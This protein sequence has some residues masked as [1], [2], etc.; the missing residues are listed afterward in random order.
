VPL[1]AFARECQRR[2]HRVTLAG[3]PSFAAQSE[4]LG[5]PYAPL[6]P[7]LHPEEQRRLFAPLMASTDLADQ[8]RATLPATVQHGPRMIAELGD[9]VRDADVLVSIPYQVAGQIVHERTGVPHVTVHFSPF[10]RRARRFADASAPLINELRWQF[11]LP[12]LAD[13]L[14]VDGISPRL[15]LHPHSAALFRKPAS[16]GAHQQVTG[17]LVLEQP[18]T[19]DADLERFVD[20]GVPPVVIGFGSMFHEDPDAVARVLVDAVARAGVRAVIQRGWSKLS[21]RDVPDDVHVTGDVPHGWWRWRHGCVGA[22][23]RA[24]CRRAALA[25][26]TSVRQPVA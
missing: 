1:W 2:G 10:A 26:P 19:P 11:G 17:F 23:W 24:L 3:P 16:W 8:I 20:G 6:G 9:V 18:V 14:G 12:P 15:A 4:R 13:P 22:R 5:V 21:P 7:V 25:G